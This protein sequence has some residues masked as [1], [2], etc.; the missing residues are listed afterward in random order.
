MHGTVWD[1]INAWV[2]DVEAVDGVEIKLEASRRRFDLSWKRSSDIIVILRA[3]ID[4]I[5]V[6]NRV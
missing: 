3:K 2:G 5:T 1:T 4:A 6:R